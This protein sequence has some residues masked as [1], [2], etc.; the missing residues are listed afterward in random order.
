MTDVTDVN[1]V[2][3]IDC[4][5]CPA[6][7]LATTDCA[8]CVIGMLL[9]VPAG[10]RLSPVG[11]S[12]DQAGRGPKAGLRIASSNRQESALELPVIKS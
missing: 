12:R 11:G 7:D 2:I 8:D 5:G 9:A 4:A 6:R 1:D 10:P 3:R